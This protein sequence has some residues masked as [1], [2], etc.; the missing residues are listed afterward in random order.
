M[1]MPQPTEVHREL[2]RLA[3]EWL[4]GAGVQE[5]DAEAVKWYR[6]AAEQGFDEAQRGLGMIEAGMTREQIAKAQ[7]LAAEWLEQY[8]GE[9]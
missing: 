3:G 8:Q 9:N 2:A 5:N 7:R 1:E 6:L 4:D